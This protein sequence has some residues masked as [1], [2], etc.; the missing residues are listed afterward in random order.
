LIN[1]PAA[2]FKDMPVHVAQPESA[3]NG[4]ISFKVYWYYWKAGGLAT[5]LFMC[6]FFMLSVGA[7]VVSSWWLAVWI[8]GDRGPFG[9]LDKWTCKYLIFHFLSKLSDKEQKS[10]FMKIFV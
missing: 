3:N 7:K 5:F 2:A 1:V 6:L 8:E 4:L 9:L 10:C